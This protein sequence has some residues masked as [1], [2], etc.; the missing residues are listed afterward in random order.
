MQRPFPN[1]RGGNSRQRFEP[2]KIV[3]YLFGVLPLAFQLQLQHLE[4]VFVPFP[5]NLFSEGGETA[6]STHLD[7]IAPVGQGP[8]GVIIFHQA[9]MTNRACAKCC[10]ML[11]EYVKTK[12]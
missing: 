12:E 5:Q 4:R 11:N 6:Y 8:E 7:G 1:I 10:T 2:S 3:N 9:A